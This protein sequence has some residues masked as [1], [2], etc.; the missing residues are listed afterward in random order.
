MQRAS[1]ARD[2][3]DATYFNGPLCREDVMYTG[4]LNRLLN[5]EIWAI[6][7]EKMRSDLQAKILKYLILHLEKKK[8]LR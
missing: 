2:R 1:Y 5:V 4:D 8:V 3:D 6:G 7:N